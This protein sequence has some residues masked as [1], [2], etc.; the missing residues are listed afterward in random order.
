MTGLVLGAGRAKSS[1]TDQKWRYAGEGLDA[2]TGHYY[3]FAR[4]MDPELGRFI[5]LDPELGRLSAPQTQN[6]YVHCVNNPKEG[7]YSGARTNQPRRSR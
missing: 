6:R 4:Y 7:K 1:G 5:S 2:S 3:N